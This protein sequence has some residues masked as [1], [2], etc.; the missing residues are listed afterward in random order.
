LDHIYHSL[1]FVAAGIDQW[2]HIGRIHSHPAGHRP[3]RGR[4]PAYSRTK[5]RIAIWGQTC[6]G[7]VF[8]KTV[9]NDA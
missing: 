2:L 4:D 9:V 7:E 1:D 8:G 6:K 5:S 3:C